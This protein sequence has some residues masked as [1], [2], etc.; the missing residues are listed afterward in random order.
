LERNLS[1]AR[2]KFGLNLKLWYKKCGQFLYFNTG[3][4]LVSKKL[5]TIFSL[6]DDYFR[7]FFEQTYLNYKLMKNKISIKELDVKFNC[8]LCA[9]NKNEGYFIHYAGIPEKV[10]LLVQ[11]YQSLT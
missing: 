1:L 3:V 5:R 7:N 8:M 11:D 10:D 9:H 6:G 2:K 4:F